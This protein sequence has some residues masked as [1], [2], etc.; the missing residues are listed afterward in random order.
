MRYYTIPLC[1]THRCNLDCVYCY[2]QH[3]S[4]HEM[5]YET[6]IQCIDK[7]LQIADENATIEFLFFGGE[8]LLRFDLIKDVVMYVEQCNTTQKCRFFASTNGTILTD[9]MRAWLEQK[10]D[11]FV[12][13]LSL[14]GT[15]KSHNTNRSN[16]FEKIDLA[17]FRNTWPNQHVKMT[18]SQKTLNNYAEDVLFLHSLGF[19]INGGDICLGDYDWEAFS[20]LNL[21]AEQISKL[22]P[23]YIKSDALYNALFD[24]DIA[25]CSSQKTPFR[26]RCGIGNELFFWDTNGEKYPCTMITPMTYSQDVLERVQMVDYSDPRNFLD[27][28]C[29]TNCYIFPICKTCSSENLLKTGSYKHWNREKCSFHEL[30]VVAKSIIEMNRILDNNSVN[31]EVHLYYGLFYKLTC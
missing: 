24:I 4:Q 9:E 3:D 26:K 11:T 12:L 16:S 22:I 19:S 6:A 13:G 28:D 5:S 30:I 1:L 15:A 31:D 8:P 14:D 7:S 23:Y 18:V 17:F 29:E 2:Q 20:C 21:F 25:L 27:E 10:K